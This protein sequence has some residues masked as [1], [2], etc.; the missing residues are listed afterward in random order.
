VAISGDT[1]V[2]GAPGEDSVATR[3]NGNQTN[4]FGP[5][6]GAAYVFVRSGTNWTQQAYLKASNGKTE[7]GFG[8][9]VA[10][11]GDTIVIGASGETNRP[12][13]NGNTNGGAAYVFVR[14]GTNWTEQAWLKASNGGTGDEFG[15]AVAIS[16]DTIVIGA[17]NEDSAATGTNGSQNNN[18]APDA[19]AAYVFVRNGTNWSQEAYLKPSNTGL[20]DRFGAAVAISGDTVVVGARYEDSSARGVNE[21]ENNDAAANS[22]AAY[23][24]V[25]TGTNWSQQAYLK[26]SNADAGDFFGDSVAVDG[27]TVVAGAAGESSRAR[28][29]NGNQTDN[30]AL[31]AGAAYVFTRSGTNW[32]Q[33]AYLKAFNGGGEDFFGTSVGVSGDTIV[34]GASGENSDGTNPWIVNTFYAGAAYV[35]VRSGTNW[36]HHAFLKASNP[37]GGPQGLHF[38][39]FGLAVAV[40]GDTVAAGL[41][42]DS[43]STGINGDPLNNNAVN[44]GAAYVFA[45]LGLGIFSDGPDGAIMRF[46]QVPGLNIQLLRA[47][48]ITGPWNSIFTN[49][50]NGLSIVQF[51]V[52]NAPA[53]RAFYRTVQE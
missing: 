16:S 48:E 9:A 13:V 26:A 34:V 25:R 21:N 50:A 5:N 14:S 10:I 44:A 6:S 20:E 2:I 51:H 32:S 31:I 36:T 47:P 4:E 52:T 43:D 18:D 40:S 28:Q 49:V 45:G 17:R 12:V 37:G 38:D 23:V 1:M 3:V 11:S 30:S 15:G 22:G 27:D 19:G 33:Q 7:N 39:S 53:S 41:W 29:V 8:G 24:F 35:F 42:D 46:K